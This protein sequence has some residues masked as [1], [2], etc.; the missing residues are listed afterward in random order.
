MKMRLE[1]LELRIFEIEKDLIEA[2]KKIQ[3]LTNYRDRVEHDNDP[4][5]G[6]F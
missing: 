5:N 6:G 2:N 1:E 3:S 4:F